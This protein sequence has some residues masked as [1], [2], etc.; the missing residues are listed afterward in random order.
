[1]YSREYGFKFVPGNFG[2]DCPGNGEDKSIECQCDECDFLMC[3]IDEDFE[4]YCTD[5][6]EYECKYNKTV[7]KWP[8]I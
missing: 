8:Y 7:K 6:I 1:M 4:K 5:C 2:K 3:C